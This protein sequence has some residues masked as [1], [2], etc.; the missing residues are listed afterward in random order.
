M[1]R[2]RN[3]LLNVNLPLTFVWWQPLRIEAGQ[4][5]STARIGLERSPV[6]ELGRPL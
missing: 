3:S 4:G 2:L 1:S 6:A 5:A